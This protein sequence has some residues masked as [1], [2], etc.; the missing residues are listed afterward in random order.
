MSGAA[1]RR[2][3][4]KRLDPKSE[5]TREPAKHLLGPDVAHRGGTHD[6]DRPF[7]EVGAG[8]C[9]GLNGLAKPHLITCH[10]CN[11]SINQSIS[12][13]DNGQA[14]AALGAGAGEACKQEGQ[15]TDQ[16]A[17]LS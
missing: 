17:P 9:N 3:A 12:R 11:Q 14:G 6:E 13:L 4:A 16:N 8:C 10:R 2:L 5:P 7:A 1:Q 15:P